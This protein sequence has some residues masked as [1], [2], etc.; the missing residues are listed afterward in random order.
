ML[1]LSVFIQ[2]ESKMQKIWIYP[3]TLIISYESY[4][5]IKALQ[6]LNVSVS[7]VLCFPI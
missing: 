5:S 3:M 2:Q 7:T 1:M 6:H 4:E